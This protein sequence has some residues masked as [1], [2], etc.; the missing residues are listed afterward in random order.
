MSAKTKK[1]KL[2]YDVYIDNKD[3]IYNTD[4]EKIFLY[5][6]YDENEAV[7][8]E[9]EYLAIL[10]I[11]EIGRIYNTD[12]EIDERKEEFMSVGTNL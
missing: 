10:A 12:N 3:K 6:G 1:Y 5:I 11:K 7:D 2:L 4:D 8:L 9:S